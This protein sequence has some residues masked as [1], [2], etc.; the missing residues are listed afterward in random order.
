[1]PTTATRTA[2]SKRAKAA[3]PQAFTFAEGQELV[4]PHR[5]ARAATIAA[6]DAVLARMRTKPKGNITKDLQEF[7]DNPRG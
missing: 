2:P 6:A 7:R 4:Y 3:K 5:P 1:M